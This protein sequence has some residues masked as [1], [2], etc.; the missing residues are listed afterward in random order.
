MEL[1]NN[2][3][4]NRTTDNFHEE[5]GSNSLDMFSSQMVMNIMDQIS[6]INT[7]SSSNN[8]QDLDANITAKYALFLKLFF[9]YIFLTCNKCV[10]IKIY[11]DSY[12]VVLTN[13]NKLFKL[14]TLQTNALKSLDVIMTSSMFVDILFNPISS[15]LKQSDA[16]KNAINDKKHRDDIIENDSMNEI[17]SF[18]FR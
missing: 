18:L 9:L 3:Q 7:N 5:N 17:L 4:L 16:N 11:R 13:E 8:T 14:C 10:L 12:S 15:K 6:E 1:P 2:N